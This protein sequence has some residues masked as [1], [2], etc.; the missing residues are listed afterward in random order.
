MLTDCR[1]NICFCE[2][3]REYFRE[4]KRK[5]NVHGRTKI[6]IF[7]RNYVILAKKL[8]IF[9][10]FFES[11][12][13]FCDLP[14]RFLKTEIFSQFFVREIFPIGKLRENGNKYFRFNPTVAVYSNSPLKLR[15]QRVERDLRT[16][17]SCTTTVI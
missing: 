9:A 1:E 2:I 13:V 12:T 14:K 3:Y 6:L 8:I 10:I 7:A 17:D 5:T 4:S 16:G 11:V 15:G